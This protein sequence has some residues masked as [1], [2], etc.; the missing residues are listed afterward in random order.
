MFCLCL[1]VVPHIYKENRTARAARYDI[2][3]VR[4]PMITNVFINVGYTY[5]SSTQRPSCSI[6]F[7]T[8]YP[9]RS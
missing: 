1:S 3:C 2:K 4:V 7:F 6:Q 9:T 5:E 8:T